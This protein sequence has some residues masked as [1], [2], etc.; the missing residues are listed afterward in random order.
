MLVQPYV[1]PHKTKFAKLEDFDAAA[2]PKGWMAQQGIYVY[3]NRRLL[4]YG[5]W[6]DI[7]KKEA[8]FNLARIRLDMNADQDYDWKI[9]IKK[10][11][12]S[13][14][15]YMKDIIERAVTVCTAQSAKVYNSRG[16]YSKNPGSQQLSYVWEQRKN[17]LGVYMFYLNKKHPMLNKV[18]KQLPSD[19]QTDLKA[20]LAL[21]EG[22]APSA[23]SGLTA[24]MSGQMN[25][26][27][28]DDDPAKLTDIAEAKGYI[29]KFLQN[30]FA[31]EEVEE[32]ILG[33][34]N[35]RYIEAELKKIFEEENY[36]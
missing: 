18:F 29:K 1:L 13:P 27:V 14:P 22:Y 5:T 17:R 21:V 12:A 2:G 9:D 30:G 25:T 6:F 4:V 32:I 16:V 8:A 10:S 23:Q 7:I 20:Y 11:V 31:K 19:G 35:Y 28:P 33:M 15:L 26:S 34:P 24:Y 3:R 36:E